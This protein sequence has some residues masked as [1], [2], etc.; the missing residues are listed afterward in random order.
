MIGNQPLL[1]PLGEGGEVSHGFQGER[2][3]GQSL[4]SKYEGG[5][6]GFR[7][8]TASEGV[9]QVKQ[10]PRTP[11]PPLHLGGKSCPVPFCFILD[12]TS[13]LYRV[14]FNEMRERGFFHLSKISPL[15][16]EIHLFSV[17]TLP[18]ILLVFSQSIK[19]NPP[20]YS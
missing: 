11:T 10:N 4:S 12:C 14:D 3:G 16:R 19:L 17:L 2:S 20:P 13:C 1:S 5:G 6:G 9:D 15:Y 7:K 8:L 18:D